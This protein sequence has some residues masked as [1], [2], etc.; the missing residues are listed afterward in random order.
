MLWP[1]GPVQFEI[2]A[3]SDQLVELKVPHRATIQSINLNEVGGGTT[4]GS[5]EIYDSE[6]AALYRLGSASASE[7]EGGEEEAHSITNG[8]ITI[9][10][11]AYS[12]RNLNIAYVNRD[13]TFT[14]PVRRLWMRVL[15]TGSGTK[16]FSLG[17]TLE[18]PSLDA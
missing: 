5:F 13:G 3:G 11:G 8:A 15:L 4:G 1:Y 16:L 2:V 6:P 12:A 9:T 7:V 10:A 14:N 18:L 17:M